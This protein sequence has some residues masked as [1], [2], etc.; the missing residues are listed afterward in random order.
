MAIS[1]YKYPQVLHLTV[2][3]ISP[4]CQRTTMIVSQHYTNST[5]KL[6][7]NTDQR[8]DL[9]L[10]DWDRRPV[11]LEVWERIFIKVFDGQ[12]EIMTK[13]AELQSFDKGHYALDF[14]K[15][16]TAAFPLGQIAYCIVINEYAD[17]LPDQ[18]IASITPA[19]TVLKT[20]MLW[21]NQEYGA[22]APLII[23]E[24]P[25]PQQA[26]ATVVPVP[27]TQL[28]SLY[29]TSALPGAAQATN[30]EGVHTAVLNLNAYTGT[31]IVEGS[32]DAD[33]P[34]SDEDWAPVDTETYTA[35]TGNVALTFLGNY[36]WVRL[37]F[38]NVM[39]L[40]GITY[41]NA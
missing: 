39:G 17:T 27:T 35:Q 26:E 32:L 16:E 37:S 6:F 3:S 34:A 22:Q 7:R 41:R 25:L 10:K 40:D 38:D 18:P 14:T 15:A 5:V 30:P 21:S 29:P 1:I 31:V 20:R 2:G 11:K 12:R 4:N 33:I 8:V 28:S 9:L 19:P 23:L 24:G 36:N 13:E